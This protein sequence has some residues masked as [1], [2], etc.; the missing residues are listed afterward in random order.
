MAMR[1]HGLLLSFGG[2][3]F[4]TV[5]AGLPGHSRTSVAAQHS[6][7]ATDEPAEV[8]LLSKEVVVPMQ[9]HGRVPV[10]E[11]SINGKG[12]FRFFIDS[13][14]SVTVL[15]DD[16]MEEL[17]LPVTG[18]TK[19]GDPADPQGITA[20]VVTV[21]RLELGG[22]SFSKF[23]AVAW[24]RST[25]RPEQDAP[26]GVL[27]V[28]LFASLLQTLDYPGGQLIMSKGELPAANGEDILDYTSREA[29]GIISIPV[30]IAGAATD[31]TM[32]SGSS[33]EFSF[34]SGYM[35]KLPLASKPVEVG[36]GRMA[37]GE[38][39]IYGAKMNGAIKIGRYTF[40][41]PTVRFN[42]RLRHI[43]IGSGL[44]SRFVI[45]IDRKNHRI[46]FKDSNKI[47][48]SV[49]PSVKPA[50]GESSEFSEY[51]GVYGGGVRQISVEGDSLYI[52]RLAGPQ[53]KGSKIK[54][55]KTAKDQFAMAGETMARI[56][57]VRGADGKVSELHVLNPAGVW[58]VSKKDI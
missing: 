9:T 5:S 1:K 45:T 22:V 49:E 17:K 10:V 58:E 42:G 28:P 30:T 52:Q 16:L 39:V 41:N 48:P 54:L 11:V 24:D 14:A 6:R 7:A 51:S 55:A 18:T 25:L 32:D 21:E 40:E 38:V 53:G 4:I 23:N 8:T 27:G 2:L 15:N 43:N 46:R 31:A 12:P 56:K 50:A 26:R 29:I 36:R 34:P 33:G 44:L 47:A 19:I 20:K 35:E 13:G 3:I 37:G 57:F